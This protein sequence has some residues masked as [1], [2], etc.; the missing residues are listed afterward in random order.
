M[1][2]STQL[3]I[4]SLVKV[5]AL[6]VLAPILIWSFIEFR[7]ARNNNHL[8]NEIKINF[9]QRYSYMNEYFLYRGEHEHEEWDE[10]YESTKHLL[11]LANKQFRKKAERQTLQKLH[12]LIKSSEAIFH[13]IVDNSENLLSDYDKHE[14]YEELD[15][16]LFSQL[17]LKSSGTRDTIT[18]LENSSSQRVERTFKRLIIILSLFAAILSALTVLTT[19]HISSLMR[20]RLTRL[21][22]GA[23]IVSAGNLSHHIE[24]N[25]DDEFSELAKSINSMTDRLNSEIKAHQLAGDELR[26][27]S[28]AIE[29]S[30]TSVV[31]T[32][33]DAHIQYVNP[34]FTEVTGYSSDEV[35]GEN[36]RILQSGDIPKAVFTELW[37]K[38]KSGSTWSGELRNKRKDGSLYWEATHIA[39]I[40][41][42]A[43]ETSHYVAIKM[44][45]TER[46]R[47]NEA[48]IE[49]EQRYHLLFNNNPMPMWLIDGA[50][51]A[52]LM[53]NERAIEHYGYSREEFSHMTLHDIR[54]SEDVPE[55]ESMVSRH[56]GFEQ[57]VEWRH[58]KKM[59]RSSMSPLALHLLCMVILPLS[60]R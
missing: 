2:I 56:P 23:K 4:I 16:R 21:H 51:L 60:F 50:S 45:I 6:L 48:L 19:M 29:Q 27:L 53:V 36:P 55:L 41:N 47:I 34:R 33:L 42:T 49:S 28:T 32:D 37:D 12:R 3:R 20:K 59:E 54:P 1:R 17:L 15:K 31:I 10:S 57:P 35:I 26:K 44:D 11:R 13:R 38:L 58:Q 7:D 5:A 18:A 30:P 43:G 22:D 52:F 25:G 46:K 9:F 24:I 39:P 8:A 14:V 40:K